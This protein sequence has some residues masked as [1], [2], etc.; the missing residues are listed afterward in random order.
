MLQSSH[1]KFALWN[2]CS[3]KSWES[4]LICP[5]LLGGLVSF[6]ER[7][8]IRVSDSGKRLYSLNFSF[9]LTNFLEFTDSVFAVY[10]CIKLALLPPN[11]M[12]LIKTKCWHCGYCDWLEQFN[13]NGGCLSYYELLSRFLQVPD[14][15]Y[16]FNVL[17]QVLHKHHIISQ[18]H[19]FFSPDYCVAF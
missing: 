16:F 9:K 17:H 11:E 19:V 5:F 18:L 8:F 1:R 14:K 3:Q 10:W 4:C 7:F 15:P 12:S 2:R 13:I 6:E